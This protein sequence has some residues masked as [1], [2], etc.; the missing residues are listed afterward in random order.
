MKL[1]LKEKKEEQI[2]NKFSMST[3]EITNI[4]TSPPLKKKSTFLFYLFGIVEI[5]V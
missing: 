2:R 3:M 4:E 1:P 5:T